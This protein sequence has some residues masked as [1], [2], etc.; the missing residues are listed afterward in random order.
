MTGYQDTLP[1]WEPVNSVLLTWRL[2]GTLAH[3]VKPTHLG[4]R[5]QAFAAFDRA[6]DT[7]ASGPIWLREPAIA[8]SVVDTLRFGERQLELYALIAFC[9]MPNHVHLLVEPKVPLAKI[10]KSIKGFTARTANQILGLTGRHFWHDD[11][12]DRW[13]RNSRE[14]S[15]MASY[16]ENNP[17]SAGLTDVAERWP[18]SSASHAVTVQLPAAL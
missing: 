7:A 16:V 3:L 9:I 10:T 14:R 18:W 8:Q 13:I 4:V 17:V 12:C 11:G 2:Q 5:D 15:R 6:L 1:R